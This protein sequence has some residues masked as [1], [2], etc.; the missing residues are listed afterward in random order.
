[1]IERHNPKSF[2][3]AGATEAEDANDPAK[4]KTKVRRLYDIAN[5]LSSLRLLDKTQ[6]PD[7]RKPAF[8]WRGCPQ[9]GELSA[10]L[11][12]GAG[13]ARTPSDHM[14]ALLDGAASE[15]GGGDTG[16][17]SSVRHVTLVPLICVP[18]FRPL[19]GPFGSF[20]FCIAAGKVLCGA[21]GSVAGLR[22]TR[23]TDLLQKGHAPRSGRDLTSVG[24]RG[25]SSV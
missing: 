3:S 4:L 1:L 8:R 14:R 7:S 22:L 15:A 5:V 6:L 11:A 13:A 17:P 18:V 21:H 19:S 23:L 25:V 20:T 10:A 24:L 12:A 16:S 2:A 9:P